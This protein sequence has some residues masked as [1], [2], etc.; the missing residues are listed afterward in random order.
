MIKGTAADLVPLDS[1]SQP[2]FKWSS[3]LWFHFP[4]SAR[5]PEIMNCSNSNFNL[6]LEAWSF[7]TPWSS[8]NSLLLPT[9]LPLSHPVVRA[10]LL[11]LLCQLQHLS[12]IVIL[13]AKSWT[14]FLRS[15]MSH[16]ASAR[17]AGN[18]GI[19]PFDIGKPFRFLQSL[20][21]SHRKV[22][23]ANA[24]SHC[25]QRSCSL[26]PQVTR[27]FPC[28]RPGGPGT[29]PSEPDRGAGVV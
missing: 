9:G 22:Y 18:S 27:S 17:E 25:Q 11:L 29:V 3:L 26:L 23:L 13:L 6:G 14:A 19:A 20:T 7:M 21:G 5:V 1:C 12:R 24:E 15:Q 28:A 4:R 16:A 10:L 2:V 8:S